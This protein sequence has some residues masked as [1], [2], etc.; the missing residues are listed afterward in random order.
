[1][2]FGDVGTRNSIIVLQ[3]LNPPDAIALKLRRAIFRFVDRSPRERQPHAPPSP[4]TI[5]PTCC[6]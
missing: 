6:I 4:A 3:L 1:M 5:D 2:T